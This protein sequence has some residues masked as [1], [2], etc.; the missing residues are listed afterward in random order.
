VDLA[1][2]KTLIRERCGLGF[3]GQGESALA[4]GLRRRCAETGAGEAA[5]LTRL[6][7]DEREFHDLVSLLTVNETYF[8]REP[9]H[10]RLLVGTLVPRMLL[11]RP[12]GAP[13]RILSAGCSSGE[14]LY[15]IAI[16]LAEQYG[17]GAA[18]RFRLAGGDI[19]TAALERARAGRYTE[20]SFRA[21]APAL[22]ARYF[23]HTD[24]Y[25][26]TVSQA[27]RAQAG[28]HHLNLLAPAYPAPF[29]TFD[30]IFFRNVSIYFDAPSRLQALRRLASL[31]A[32]Q[33]VLITGSAE[34]LANDLGVLRLVREDGLFYFSN[35]PAA[36]APAARKKGAPAP[37]P[38]PSP[39][40][41]PSAAAAVPAPAVSSLQLVREATELI[42]AKQFERAGDLLARAD[43]DAPQAMLLGSYLALQRKQYAASEQLARQ[44]LALDA[45]SIDALLLLALAAKWQERAAETMQWLKQAVYACP[46]CWPAHYYLAE[47]HR[48]DGQGEAARRAYR[49][50]LQL[51]S[52]PGAGDAGLRVI[53]LDLPEAELRFL[54]QHQLAQLAQPSAP[55]D[56]RKGG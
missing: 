2:F 28:F 47:R 56:A 4:S 15:S 45:W 34:T 53:P 11:A 10:L 16:A 31:L 42:R 27:L 49:V 44:V 22:R 23:D 7:S 9:E 8:Y 55:A 17:A 50:T 21:M 13:L 18:H 3:E 51:L 36:A 41:T 40:P 48:A 43:G 29:E 25:G 33:A 30:V 37:A 1:P 32:P 54:C 19:D 26:W 12:A 14:E 39:A 38:A 24:Q 20:F 35:A 46:A 52:D 6:R 5:Y